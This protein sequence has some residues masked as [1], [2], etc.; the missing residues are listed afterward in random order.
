MKTLAIGLSLA[1]LL[2]SSARAQQ[3]GYDYNNYSNEPVDPYAYPLPSP[4]PYATEVINPDDTWDED[5]YDVDY[6]V[7]YDTVAAENYDDGYDPNAYTQFQSALSPYGDWVSDPTYGEVWV[8]SVDVVGANFVPYDSCGH[9]VLTEYGWT[10]VSDCWDWGWAPFHYGRWID[11][12]GWG[13]CWVPGTVWGP[14]WVSWR[15]GGGYVGWAPLPPRGVTVGPPRGVRSPWRFELAHELGVRSPH[16]LPARVVPAVFAH[17][18]VITNLRTANNARYNAGPSPSGLHLPVRPIPLHQAAPRAL[19]HPSVIARPSMP[20]QQRPW[21][22]NAPRPSIPLRPAGP[23]PRSVTIGQSIGRAPTPIVRRPFGP[24]V[25]PPR[26]LP[27]SRPLNG[28]LTVVRPQYQQ[29][30]G[31]VPVYRAPAYQAPNYHSYQAPA[32][33]APTYQ[34]PSYHAAPTY[35]APAAPMYHAPAPTYHAPSAPSYHAPAPTY[36]AP[37]P[38]Y[39]APSA[40]HFSGG[41]SRHR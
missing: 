7:Y 21:V 8:P 26:P 3:P 13:W 11:L 33:R 35:H 38:T 37:A 1:T 34:A 20:L 6:D 2:G 40:P 27:Q 36:H 32:Y 28:T 31:Q 19:P 23:G 5:G 29:P 4:A 24:P 15:S 10:W 41:G 16:V 14:G 30:A 22:K 25:M 9:W 12:V 17:T 39:H 18:S